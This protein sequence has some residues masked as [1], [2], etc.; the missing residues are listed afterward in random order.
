MK[1]KERVIRSSRM[2]PDAYVGFLK[3]WLTPPGAPAPSSPDV[4]AY[5]RHANEKAPLPSHLCI[6]REH[7]TDQ[8]A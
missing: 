2:S 5:L 1:T 3:L 6:P 4:D 7:P 8:A